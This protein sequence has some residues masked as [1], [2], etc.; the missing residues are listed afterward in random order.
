MKLTMNE[1]ADGGEKMVL[2]GN[3][4]EV[5]FIR[6]FQAKGLNTYGL[7]GL[8][9][10]LYAESGCNSRNLENTYE[11]KLGMT[12][13]EYTA[14]VDN[15]TYRNFVK[16]SAGYGIAQWTFWTR[17]Q[18]LLNYARSKNKSIGDLEMQ[19][20]FLYKELS[21]SYSDVLNVLKTAKTVLE[22][23]NAVLL[24]F[25]R[26]ADQS[27]SVQK[28]RAGYGETFYEKYLKEDEIMANV[29]DNTPDSW[30][31]EAVEWAVN[32]KILMG[33]EKGNYKLHDD[34][35]RQ[36][37]LVFLNRLYKLVR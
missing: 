26:P 30:A 35:T 27:I 22:A 2:A 20:E 19:F 5:Q 15:G 3:S 25:E 8:Y 16:D 23:S 13:A 9:G 7:A 21:E 29:K 10:N 1:I 4:V 37:M 34:C 12:D 31:K 14:A 28:R 17:K 33:D 11:R 36:E 32:N 18:A 24:Q 6:F